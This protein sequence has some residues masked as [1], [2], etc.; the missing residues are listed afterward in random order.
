MVNP[1]VTEVCTFEHLLYLETLPDLRF[2]C[3]WLIQGHYIFVLY[4]DV[5]T[6]LCYVI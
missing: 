1:C 6:I 4:P 3:V 2:P 5:L